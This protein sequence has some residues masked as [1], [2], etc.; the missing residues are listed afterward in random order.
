VLLIAWVA[1]L[2]NEVRNAALG[3]IAKSAISLI[4]P[5]S[6][7][8]STPLRVTANVRESSERSFSTM[9]WLGGGA[10]RRLDALAAKRLVT[11]ALIAEGKALLLRIVGMLTKLVEH[12]DAYRAREDEEADE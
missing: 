6:P 12:F 3:F 10:S 8:Y 7:P 11:T 2:L 4:A 9:A 5:A 1:I